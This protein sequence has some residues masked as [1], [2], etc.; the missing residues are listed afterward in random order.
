MEDTPVADVTTD[1]RFLVV[2]GYTE[3]AE[4]PCITAAGADADLLPYTPSLDLE[5]VEHGE[6]SGGRS[7]P[8]SPTG[9]P[10]PA[11]ASRAAVELLDIPFRAVDAGVARPSKASTVELASR[12]GR[13]IRE[14]EAVADAL[15][16]HDRGRELGRTLTESRVVVGE[17][18]PGGTTT[19][20]AV[21]DAL[22]EGCSTSSSLPDSPTELKQ[23]VVNEAL[24]VSDVEPGGLAGKPMD[25]LRFVGDP[26]LAAVSGVASGALESGKEVVLAGGTQMLAAAAVLRHIGVDEPLEIATT[27]YVAEDPVCD[28]EADG[29]RLDV[30]VTVTDPEFERSEIAG[31][32]RYAD[33]E[34]KE[35]VGL[36]GLLK[37][38]AESDRD[39]SELR[40]RTE[41]VYSRL[42][43]AD[44]VE[45]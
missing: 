23:E 13:D 37:L 45:V 7:P 35:G 29:A 20:L 44:E 39:M 15:Q 40:Q 17:S 26:V 8:V 11:V 3:T 25:A 33:G 2:A 19:A 28:V 27:R 41:E 36:G 42:L 18:I 10:T 5:V 12:A 22:G 34:A 32:Q 30:D 16:V 9:C 4:I 21:T 14:N 43:D 38:V 1:T 6:V 31:L 24:E